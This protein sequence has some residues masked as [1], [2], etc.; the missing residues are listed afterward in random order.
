MKWIKR[1]F[2]QAEKIEELEIVIEEYSQLVKDI[3]YTEKA[4]KQI[5]DKD[6]SWY[7]FTTLSL[8]D[9]R[10]YFE[11]A[12]QIL[13]TDVFHNEIN[14][15]TEDIFKDNMIKNTDNDTQRLRDGR[16]SILTLDLLRKRLEL[17]KYEIPRKKE[18]VKD[19]H[20]A[21]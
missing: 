6:I 13:N 10:K 9:Q 4:I 18:T 11:Q 17:I 20:S 1:L 21:I 8:E 5:L 16:V 19:P 14:A 7:D 15:M 2:K 3:K 12:Q